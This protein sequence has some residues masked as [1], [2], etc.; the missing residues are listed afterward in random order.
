MQNP[1]PYTIRCAFFSNST[2]E[3][4]C[5]PNVTQCYCVTFIKTRKLIDMTEITPCFDYF[6]YQ[7]IILNVTYRLFVFNKLNKFKGDNYGVCSTNP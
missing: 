3:N 6:I 5:K 2:W 1:T 7:F 4:G